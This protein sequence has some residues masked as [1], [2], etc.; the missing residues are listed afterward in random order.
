MENLWLNKLF[1]LCFQFPDM[2]SLCAVVF[3]IL[4]MQQTTIPMLP[5]LLLLLECAW[6]L[7]VRLNL[8]WERV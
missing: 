3:E 8:K 6:A 1:E 5:M 7:E 2:L 4:K